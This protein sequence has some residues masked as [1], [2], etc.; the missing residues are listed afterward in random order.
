MIS[1]DEETGNFTEELKKMPHE[2]VTQFI[3]WIKSKMSELLEEEN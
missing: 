2:L 3:D 1:Y